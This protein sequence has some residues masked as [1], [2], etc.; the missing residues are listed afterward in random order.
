[1]QGVIKAEAPNENL[2]KWEAQISYTLGT[3]KK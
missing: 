2:E 3:F 1:M